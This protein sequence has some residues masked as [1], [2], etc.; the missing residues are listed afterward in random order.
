MTTIPGVGPDAAVVVN[1]AGGKQ[2]QTAGRFDL[3]DAPAMFQIAGILDAGAAKYGE[4][5]WRLIPTRPHLNAALAHIYAWLA[6]DRQ[7]DHLG[8]AFCRLM[9]ACAT[10]NQETDR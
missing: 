5:N 2:S 3:L 9:F 10:E 7:D 6:G 4:D 8:H 1:A